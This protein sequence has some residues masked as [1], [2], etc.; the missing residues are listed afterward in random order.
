M[1][2]FKSPH[3]SRIPPSAVRSASGAEKVPHQANVCGCGRVQGTAS[4]STEITRCCLVREWGRGQ[5]RAQNEGYGHCNDRK[6]SS[7]WWRGRI[8]S[9]NILCF[10]PVY[11][12]Y[13]PTHLTRLQLE[14]RLSSGRK[15]QRQLFPIYPA[16]FS[17]VGRGLCM[18][19][20]LAPS[21]KLRCCSAKPLTDVCAFQTRLSREKAPSSSHKQITPSY[22]TRFQISILDIS[23]T[24]DIQ[25]GIYSSILS[26]I[27]KANLV[28]PRPRRSFPTFGVRGSCSCFSW[29][30]PI[31]QTNTNSLFIVAVKSLTCPIRR[32]NDPISDV[33]TSIDYRAGP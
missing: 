18:Y 29:L 5:S 8:S 4:N 7:P 27:V 20:R 28:A 2:P 15:T 17:S 14:K 33:G 9:I 6:K 24:R 16:P 3:C 12:F 10:P 1:S 21:W 13:F 11:I 30:W 26:S 31:F 32:E 23:P 22:R 25:N 19:F